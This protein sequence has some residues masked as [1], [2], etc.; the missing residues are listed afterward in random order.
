MSEHIIKS[1]NKS[2]L[3][4][5]LVC[6]VKYRK[7]AI[8]AGVSETIK[9]TCLEISERYEMHFV[10]IGTDEDHVHFLVQSISTMSPTKIVTIIKS[11]T[12]RKIFEIHPEIRLLL[13]GG[14]FWTGGFYLN[15]VGQ[16][17]NEQVIK[18][19][20]KQQGKKYQQLH[21]TQLTLFD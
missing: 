5:H 3:L 18:N 2:L 21:R 4:Y 15:T 1:H 12:A 10:E 16:Y 19:Y 8:S 17:G 11:F 14:K 7:Q 20:I 6:P 9:S 13:W